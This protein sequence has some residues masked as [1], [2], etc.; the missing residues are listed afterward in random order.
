MPT[1]LNVD[2]RDALPSTRASVE[3]IVPI[4]S[5]GQLCLA[6]IAL[7]GVCGSKSWA[8]DTIRLGIIGLDT[9]HAIAFTELLNGE[10][11]DAAFQGCRIVAA[12]PQG[13]RD[14][15]SSVS[16]V[17]QYTETVR[18]LG[19]EIVDSIETLVE[20][21]D[22]V[23]LES[24]DG[25]PHLEQVLPVINAGKPVFIDKPIAG[26]LVDA[27]RIFDAA[28]QAGVPVWSASSLRY[29]EQT[30]AVRN[31]SVGSVLG[32]DAYSPAALESTHPDL[33]WYGIHGVETLFT[34]MGPQCERVVRVSTADT[35]VAVG[36]WT[37][38]RIGTFRGTRSGK[39]GYGGTVFGTTG[40]VHIDKYDGYQ[41]LVAQLVTFFKT[42]Q[43]PVSAEETLAIYAF[44]EAADESKRQGGIPVSVA[45]CLQKAQQAA[46]SS[47]DKR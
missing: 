15:E 38:G 36:T 35:D 9:S 2:R 25:R 29:N 41:P 45:D 18:G 24:N 28:Q 31:G 4:G 16:R 33:F 3:A 22:G 14:I 17:P 21:V 7:L 34:V 26:S 30:Q 20:R 32:C 43:P 44:M 11:P 8:E 6:L 39:H 46:R 1:L 37:D 13:S 5:F 27:V 42:K 23:L 47:A 40:V 19:V 12:Y 10:S